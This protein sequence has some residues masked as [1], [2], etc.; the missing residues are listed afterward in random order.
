MSGIS[1]EIDEQKFCARLHRRSDPSQ[2]LQVVCR[3]QDMDCVR[4]EQDIMVTGK[5]CFEEVAFYDIDPR[6]LRFLRQSLPPDR[7]RSR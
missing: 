5:R 4:Y 6:S 1:P 3:R 7:T 2:E